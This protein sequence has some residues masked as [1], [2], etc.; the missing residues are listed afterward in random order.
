M[1]YQT[2]T[3]ANMH[4]H[5]AFF[6]GT[7]VRIPPPK[8][9]YQEHLV[10]LFYVL[11]CDQINFSLVISKIQLLFKVSLACLQTNSVHCI[12]DLTDKGMGVRQSFETGLEIAELLFQSVCNLG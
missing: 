2:I 1:N 3:D 10:T 8:I 7:Q 5:N 11:Q 6:S 12:I 4:L 9:I